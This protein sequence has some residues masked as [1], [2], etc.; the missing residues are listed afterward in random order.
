MYVC[1]CKNVTERQVRCAVSQ[2]HCSMK[3][4]CSELGVMGQCGKC[5]KHT[6][7]LLRQWQ[8]ERPVATTA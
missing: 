1:V 4:L 5:A 6:R 8:H 3:S 7:E 2:G